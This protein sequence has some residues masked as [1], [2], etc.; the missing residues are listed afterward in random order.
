MIRSR[1]LVDALLI[2]PHH[3]QADLKPEL[4]AWCQGMKTFSFVASSCTKNDHSTKTGCGT[5]T[6]GKLRKKD[7]LS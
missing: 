5:T 1:Y 6:Q 3:P 4:K 2:D 7:G